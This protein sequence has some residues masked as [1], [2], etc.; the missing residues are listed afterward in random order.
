MTVFR[1]SFDRTDRLCRTCEKVWFTPSSANQKDCVG[2]RKKREAERFS[3]ANKKMRMLRKQKAKICEFCDHRIGTDCYNHSSGEDQTT[4]RYRQTCR[5][6]RARIGKRR[7][8]YKC[9]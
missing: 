2:C 7:A 4:V 1:F 5:N 9:V 3:E 8:R 6:W